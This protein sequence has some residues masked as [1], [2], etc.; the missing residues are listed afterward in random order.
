[1]F[2]L[3]PSAKKN[4]GIGGTGF[5]GCAEACDFMDCVI[6]LGKNHDEVRDELEGLEMSYLGAQGVDD[7]EVTLRDMSPISPRMTRLALTTEF[8]NG[9]G[10]TSR[11]T[12]YR[13]RDL[14]RLW[15]YRNGGSPKTDEVDL[16]IAR[17][18]TI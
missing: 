4:G 6:E 11:R 3:R 2:P 14:S 13:V 9:R 10:M 18:S 1:M 15:L 8:T 7:E 5:E 17:M 12:E 16:G